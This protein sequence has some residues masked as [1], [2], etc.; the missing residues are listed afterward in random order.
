MLQTAMAI[1]M[2]LNQSDTET[3]D[4][5]VFDTDGK[6]IEGAIVVVSTC[7]PRT[8]PA[9]TCPSCYLDCSKKTLTNASGKFAIDGLS[10]KLQFS[11]AVGGINYQGIVTKHFDPQDNPTIEFN[12]ME[13]PV[14][15]TSRRIQGRVTDSKGASVVGAEIRSHL[16]RNSDGRMSSNES[17]VTPLTISDQQGNFVVCVGE[18]V[19]Q[20]H[21]RV[22]AGGF[23]P[24]Q[25]LWQPKSAEPIS[26]ELAEG[27]SIRGQL[28]HDGEPIVGAMMG[29][30][31]SDRSIGNI[32]TPQEL[33]TDDEGI[34]QFEGLPPDIDYAIYTVMHQSIAATLPVSL[35]KA[36][37]NGQLA[38]LGE[39]A[40]QS[41]KALSIIV[42]TDD[43]G[44][45]PA[46]GRVFVSRSK[47]WHTSQLP[48]PAGD[49]K[50][51]VTLPSV[52][53]EMVEIAVRVPGFK[54]KKTMPE[55]QIDMNRRY[56]LRLETSIVV[57][58]VL[59][60]DK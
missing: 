33:C 58:V 47:A 45:L 40:T 43:N 7:R 51:V 1:C 26:I 48:L 2:L 5:Y 15:N 9:T 22:S 10:P 4:G 27:A 6:P 46:N 21:W 59:T 25:F 36:P 35:I 16:V 54:V 44:P 60:S 37:A 42:E 34:F 41:A 23:A 53:R 14:A 29:I 31:Q 8:G 39:I 3:L 28:V 17:T 52:G 20:V 57:T 18:A 13:L 19:S 11:L 24:N 30:V 49:S 56:Q 55:L 32:V 50:V 38:D 12:L